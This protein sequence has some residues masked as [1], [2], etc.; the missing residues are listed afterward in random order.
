M[1]EILVIETAFRDLMEHGSWNGSGRGS[2]LTDTE[3]RFYSWTD[4]Y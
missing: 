2:Y 4:L 1:K 3:Y